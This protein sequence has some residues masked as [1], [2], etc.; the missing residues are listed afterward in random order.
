MKI[1]NEAWGSNVL[2]T[3]RCC[4]VA[5]YWN[6][7]ADLTFS[8]WSRIWSLSTLG[9]YF[10]QLLVLWGY[11]FYLL[12]RD[13]R[14]FISWR[15]KHITS[16]AKSIK[17]TLSIVWRRSISQRVRYGRFH[18]HKILKAFTRHLA[19]CQRR[20]LANDTNITSQRRTSRIYLCLKYS[21]D[22]RSHWL[23]YVS[24][25]HIV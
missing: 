19:R 10:V 14:L 7:D 15:L 23:K 6:L 1:L 20:T 9:G 17:G 2:S 8:T 22:C 24:N 4:W 16:M 21:K 5:I 13:R 11:V 12:S 25:V 18:C 3:C